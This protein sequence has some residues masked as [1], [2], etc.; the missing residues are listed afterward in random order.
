MH[1]DTIAEKR[2][3]VA[4]IV[5]ILTEY[6]YQNIRHVETDVRITRDNS[7]VAAQGHLYA[8]VEEAPGHANT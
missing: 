2:R 6:G 8:V 4:E 3:K 7:S 5:D 1:G